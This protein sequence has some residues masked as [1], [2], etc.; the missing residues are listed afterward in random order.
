MKKSILMLTML[1]M[2][3]SSSFAYDNGIGVLA[4]PGPYGSGDSDIAVINAY[5][6]IEFRYVIHRADPDYHYSGSVWLTQFGSTLRGLS[7]GGNDAIYHSDSEVL[8]G[9][10]STLT[11][12]ATSNNAYAHGLLYW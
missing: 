11:L 5:C 8:I 9:Q 7:V 12:T 10:W 3:F 4:T 2:A 1:L 6:E